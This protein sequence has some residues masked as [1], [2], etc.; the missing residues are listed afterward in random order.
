MVMK[1][2]RVVKHRN[3]NT[4]VRNATL[5]TY[6]KVEYKSKL[7]AFTAKVLDESGILYGYETSKFI[8][9]DSF[10]YEEDTYRQ[11]GTGTKKKYSTQNRKVQPITYKP[12]FVS[13][14]PKT[15]TGWVIEVKGFANDAFPLRFKLFK[16]FLH[17]NGYR[18]VLFIP[19]NQKQVRESIEKIKNLKI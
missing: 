9:M 6:G 17:D 3:S 12:D 1:R 2:R 7:E 19:R 16:K 18:V 13:I 8:L 14:N 15:K 10:T 11:T 5:T 4:K